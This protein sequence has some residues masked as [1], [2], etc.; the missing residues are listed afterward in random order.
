MT[1][2]AAVFYDQ[3]VTLLA[4]YAHPDV[5]DEDAQERASDYFRRNLKDVTPNIERAGEEPLRLDLTLKDGTRLWLDVATPHWE[6]A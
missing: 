3:L 6:R 4:G 1:D 5:V 2:E